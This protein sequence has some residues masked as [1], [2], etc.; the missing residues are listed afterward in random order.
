MQRRVGEL[1]LHLGPLVVEHPQR[2]DL[3]PA[4][5]CRLVEVEPAQELLQQRAVGRAAV[6]GQPSELS[7][8]AHPVRP[9][10]AEAGVGERDDLGVERRVVAADRLDADLV[11]TAGSGRP[12]G[13]RRGRTGP[14][15]QSFTGSWPR[16]QAVLEHG[17]H[18]RPRC[19]PGAA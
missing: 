17:A 13:A 14:A 5:R 3:G 15:Y 12:A 16:S 6:R 19:P 10:R 11:R 1:R 2:V 7:S 18:A 4:P 9:E 8:S